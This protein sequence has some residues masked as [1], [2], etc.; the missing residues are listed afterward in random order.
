MKRY[1]EFSKF[2]HF[3]TSLRR[4]RPLLVFVC[5]FASLMLVMA[6]TRGSWWYPHEDPVASEK[7]NRDGIAALFTPSKSQ[8]LATEP[9]VPAGQVR[10]SPIAGNEEGRD[11]CIDPQYQQLDLGR[12]VPIRP[13][14]RYEACLNQTVSAGGICLDLLPNIQLLGPAHDSRVPAPSN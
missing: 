1:F 12:T 11:Q 5:V 10:Q 14:C 4:S 7:V 6:S 2:A 13:S 3:A 9:I 8:L